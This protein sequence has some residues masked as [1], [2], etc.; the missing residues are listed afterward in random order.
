MKASDQ[1]VGGNHYKDNFEIQPSEFIQRNN[2]GWCEGNAVKYAC[3]HRFKNGRQDIEKAIHYLNLLLE[4]EYPPTAADFPPLPPAE[5]AAIAEEVVYHSQGKVDLCATCDLDDN[6]CFFG[7]APHLSCS[8]YKERK[9]EPLDFELPSIT[10]EGD[11]T[12]VWEKY[13]EERDEY[14]RACE[15]G[16]SDMDCLVELWDCIQ[17][18]QTHKERGGHSP[19]TYM[20]YCGY[21]ND[22]AEAGM[23]VMEARRQMLLKNASRP[24]PGGGTGYYSPKTC[25]IILASDGRRWK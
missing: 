20:R 9:P 5:A 11:E 4:W 18:L 1:Q 16:A 25:K 19:Q 13:K 7:E 12:D 2:L 10:L 8:S 15:E 17:V 3:R 6:G 14:E 24:R 23:P 21:M 22:E